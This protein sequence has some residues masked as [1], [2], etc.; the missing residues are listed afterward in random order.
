V[1]TFLGAVILAGRRIS[2]R[3]EE[4]A[5]MFFDPDIRELL[6]TRPSPLT[7]DQARAMRGAR[8][9]GPPPRPS[10]E[11][12]TAQGRVSNTGVIVVAGQK[13]A[14]GRIYAG[15]VAIVH[16]AAETVTI[17]LCGDTRTVRGPPPSQL[18]M[19]VD[20]HPHSICSIGRSAAQRRFTG[21]PQRT[22]RSASAQQCSDRTRR[23]HR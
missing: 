4:A 2:I 14:L 21:L 16:V 17:D 15:R 6:R 1:T 19:L 10:T 5:L 8:P 11:P 3:I 7:W 12:V 23:L 13:I 9:V 22:D 18:D 20:G